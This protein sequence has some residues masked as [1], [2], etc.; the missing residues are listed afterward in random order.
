MEVDYQRALGIALTKRDL[1][2]QREIE[3]PIV[4]EGV[5]I[6][7]RRVDFVINDQQDEL[8]L[9]TKAASQIKPEDVEQC[10]LYLNQ[11]NYHLCLLVNFGVKPLQIQRFVR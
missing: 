9:E 8:I 4:Y 7:R 1:T 11:G 3:I 5:I 10:L 2:W 6:T